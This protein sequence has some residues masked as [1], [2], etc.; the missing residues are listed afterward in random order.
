MVR[1]EQSSHEAADQRLEHRVV[2]ALLNARAPHLRFL[3]VHAG[4]RRSLRLVL[5]YQRVV[6]IAAHQ[7]TVT[8]RG[9]IGGQRERQMLVALVKHVPGVAQVVDRLKIVSQ[10][11]FAPQLAG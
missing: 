9:S 10:R 2:L 1:I 5:P 6:E 8:L 4:P 11:R 7:A 3:H